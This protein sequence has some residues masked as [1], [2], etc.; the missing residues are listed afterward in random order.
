VKAKIELSRRD[1]TKITVGYDGNSMSVEVSRTKFEEL[2][3]HL[4]E[5]CRVL[6][7]DALA[8]SGKAWSEIDTVLLVGGSTRMPMVT[9]MIEQISGKKP[10]VDVNPDECVAHGAAWHASM[11]QLKAE[12]SVRAEWQVQNPALARTLNQVEVCEV[13]AHDYGTVAFDE[14]DHERSFR[15]LPKFSAVP[16]EK[17][18][19]F[20]T[21][22]D[23]QTIVNFAVTEGGLYLS[24]NTCNP[25]DCQKLGVLTLGPIPPRPVGSPIEIRYSFRKDKILEV[26]ARDLGSGVAVRT[27]IKRE[28]GLT[29][30]ERAAAA[31]HMSAAE[32]TG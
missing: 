9:Q 8:A 1:R 30:A 17:T 20:T 16:S 24:S 27:E 26:S 29:G 25:D 15:M 22:Y 14:H 10:S 23:N 5:R 18:D 31:R 3:S 11:L 13:T 4:V 12:P 6:C 2:T 32:V 28:G 19:V 21:R 7:E